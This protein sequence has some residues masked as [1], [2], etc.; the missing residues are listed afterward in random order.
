MKIS[1]GNLRTLIREMLKE[2]VDYDRIGQ[3]KTDLRDMLAKDFDVVDRNVRHPYGRNRGDV[4]AKTNYT[5][6]DGQ[7]ISP[8]NTRIFDDLTA[9]Q[10]GDYMRA[11][12]GIYSYKISE[13]GMTLE[14][15]YYQHTAG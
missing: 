13:D 9:A 3:I 6:K 12:G 14:V 15:D 4:K 8:E 7:P 1:R 5:R 10:K 11:L 2:N